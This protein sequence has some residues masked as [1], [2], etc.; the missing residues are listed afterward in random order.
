M[1]LLAF[2]LQIAGLALTLVGSSLLLR[3]SFITD[4]EIEKLT[5]LPIH[6]S[7][8]FGHGGHRYA[9]TD[10]EK[11]EAYKNL[12]LQERTGQRKIGRIALGLFIAGFALQL[13]G[14]F[15]PEILTWIC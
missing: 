13:A 15:I 5:K 2:W 1:M 6:A 12:Y 3:G 11:L 10:P 8:N 9:S 14:L 7:N 4:R